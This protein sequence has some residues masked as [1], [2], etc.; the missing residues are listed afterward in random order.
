MRKAGRKLRDI[1]RRIDILVVFYSLYRGRDVIRRSIR[2]YCATLHGP[3][4][5]L[6]T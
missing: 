2:S 5:C 1:S 4:P 6:N 3:E